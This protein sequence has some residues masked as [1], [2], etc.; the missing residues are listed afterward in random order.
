MG[1]ANNSLISHTHIALVLKA[2]PVMSAQAAQ[3]KELYQNEE[4]RKGAVNVP[5]PDGFRD[6]SLDHH[7]LGYL[8]HPVQDPKNWLKYRL[9]QEQVD[10]YWRDGYLTNIR[11][12]SDDD[13]DLILKDYEIFL[14][15]NIMIL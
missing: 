14:V 8:C 11:V 6:L 15:R 4:H 10:Q 1:V 13:C 12:L 2:L 3:E 5:I 7:P 9:T